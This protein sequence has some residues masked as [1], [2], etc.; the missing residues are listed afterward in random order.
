MRPAPCPATCDSL[1]HLW[2]F[3]FAALY[4]GLSAPR[5]GRNTVS[6]AE[7]PFVAALVVDRVFL[8]SRR[9]WFVG[10][11]LGRC[12]QGPDPKG[13]GGGGLGG[14]RGDPDV[15]GFKGALGQNGD[16]RAQGQHDKPQPNPGHDGIDQGPNKGRVGGKVPV[17]E[18]QIEV[19]G[20]GASDGYLCC[21]LFRVA[22]VV[23]A[24][25]QK[26]RL[27]S[28]PSKVNFAPMVSF[29]H[30]LGVVSRCI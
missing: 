24:R 2:C 1:W 14:P 15:N 22:L 17:Y 29:H 19:L 6:D 9:V 11:C 7:P 26:G 28:A 3:R 27:K 5:L 18:N 16:A 23:P 25:W 8:V 13:D 30:L 12:C 4:S 21:G 10:L 20:G